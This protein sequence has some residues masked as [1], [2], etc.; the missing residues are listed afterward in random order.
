VE[1][2][3]TPGVKPDTIPGVLV[4]GGAALADEICPPGVVCVASI[5]TADVTTTVLV[6]T[7]PFVPAA[8]GSG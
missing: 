1:L 5:V 8:D 6:D 3:T 7:E 4:K 2:G